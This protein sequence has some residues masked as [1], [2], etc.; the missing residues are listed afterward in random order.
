MTTAVVLFLGSQVVGAQEAADPA[1]SKPVD[2]TDLSLEELATLKVASVYGASKHQ[3]IETEAPSSVSIVTADDIRKSG[4]RTLSDLLNGV[5]G[6]YTTYDRGYHYIGV[7]GINRP[8][9]FGGRVLITVDGHRLNDPIFDSAANGNEFILDMDLVDRVE[10]IRG[11]GSSLYGNNAFLAVINVITR[12]GESFRGAEVSGAY[13]S[14]DTYTGR[15]SYGNRFDNGLEL[16]LSGT[17]LNSQGHDSLY[18]PEFSLAN[19]GWADKADGAWAGSG[20]AQLRYGDFSLEGGVVRRKKYLPTAAY[21]AAFNDPRESIDDERAFADLKYQHEFGEEWELIARGYYDHYRYEG[22]VPLPEV[23]YGNPLYPGQITL[24]Q[25]ADRS[26]SVGV[27]VQLSKN[28]FEGNRLTAGTEYRNDFMLQFR[29]F[30][31][32]P[33]ATFLDTNLTAYTVGVFV[34]DEYQICPQFIVNAG[35]RYDYFSSFGDTVNPRVALIYSPWKEGSFKFLY[36]QAFRAPNANELYYQA[37]GYRSNLSL[38]PE[39]THSYELV[40]EQAAGNHLR[41]VSCLFYEQIADLITFGSTSDAVVFGNITGATSRGGELELQGRWAHGWQALASYTYA[42]ARDTQTDQRLNNSPE[43][44]AKFSLTA[45][46]WKQKLFANLEIQA[47]SSRTTVHGGSVDGYWV[48]NATLLS[49]E[50][51]K[52]LDLSASVY[53][54]FNQHYA[55]PVAADLPENAVQQDGIGFRLKLTYRF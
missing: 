41:L 36:G 14:Y 15:L 21:G 2:L 37:P 42:N 54:L 33:P 25:D 44:L 19:Q 48:A 52:G 11:P 39:T 22:V 4:Y 6:F 53:N 23:E 12:R 55:D 50:L 24:N 46:L 17:Y 35:I 3:Q 1:V 7:R 40:Y 32:D 51:L 38:K 45:P 28:L 10:V 29:N 9:D 20:F 47:V 5:R 34:Q 13:A 18:F 49:R 31:V 30:D 43:H 27:E 8:G 16:V 26:E